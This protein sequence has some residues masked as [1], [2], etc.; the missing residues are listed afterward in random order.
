M[1]YIR[2]D[3]DHTSYILDLTSFGIPKMIY[4]G[5]LLDKNTDPKQLGMAISKPVYQAGL[6]TP[7]H[8]N[9]FPEHGTGFRGKPAHLGHRNGIDWATQFKIKQTNQNGQHIQ[10]ILVDDIANLELILEIIMDQASG[11]LARRSCLKN[12][13]K[14]PYQLHYCASGAIEIPGFCEELLTF[15]GCWTGEFMIQRESFS[16]G[17]K[18]FE[19]QTG[20]TSHETFPGMIVGSKGF[21][22]TFGTVFGCHLGWSGNHRVFAEVIPDGSRQIQMGEYLFPG[23]IILEKNESYKSPWI[24]SVCSNQGL[25]GLSGKL[26]SFLRNNIIPDSVRIKPR[27]VQFNSW[28]AVY[29]D[30][31]MEK[32]K[33][34]ALKA[35]GLG[36]E[37]F[38]LDDGWFHRRDDDT[39]ALGDWWPDKKKYPN[40]LSPLI[41]YVKSLDLDFGLWVEPEMVNPDSELFK[42]HPDWVLNIEGHANKTARNQLVLNLRKDAVF[43]YLYEKLDYLLSNN[44]IDYLKWDMNRVL[45]TAGNDGIPGFHDQTNA[46]YRLIKKIR[47]KHP[48][49]EIET[50]ASGG[51][52]VD[53]EI[54]KHTHRFWA[55]DS[56]DPLQRQRIQKGSSIFFP[57]EITGSHIGPAECHTSGRVTSLSFRA[58]TSLFYHF[59]CEMNLLE[60]TPDEEDLLKQY[61]DIHKKYRKLSHHGTYVRLNLD[62]THRNGYGSI[63]KDL[64]AALFC[65]V[66]METPG[67]NDNQV[68]RFCGLSTSKMYRIRLLKPVDKSIEDRLKNTEF[69]FKGYN[70]TGQV[71]MESGISIFMPWPQTG[72]LIE[73]TQIDESR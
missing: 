56:N 23:E 55:S 41:D 30:H 26:H 5:P 9:L 36:I 60:L 68:I 25:N 57:P 1:S 10:I 12:T 40:G 19:N 65:I 31:D 13:F 37:R 46:V 45:T 44:S 63:S 33:S 49:I 11:V 8:L 47:R 51:G 17:I 32:L 27:P 39:K 67:H 29:F 70:L 16:K 69:W 34:L 20:R 62:K 71:L 48:Y 22:E 14:T 24:Y 38:V 43:D 3:S 50:C 53:Y 6:D 52:R 59:G 2:I 42:N 15:H 35:A 61:I 7:Y 64:S 4:W 72:I 66:Q 58:I 54:L 21:N 73:L 18:L 28:E